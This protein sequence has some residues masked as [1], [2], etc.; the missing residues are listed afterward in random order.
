MMWAA[1]FGRLELRGEGGDTRLRGRFP[2]GAA[3]VLSAGPPERRERFAPRAFAARI[4]AGDDIRLLVG[5]DFGKPLASR[6]AGSLTL[7]DD[8]EALTFEAV[9]P[10]ALRAAPY[11]ADVLAAHAAGLI[12]GLS[13]GFRVPPG[14]DAVQRDGDGL[15]R[16]VRM[17]DLIELS[18]VSAPAYPTA[19]VEAR[20]W[21]PPQAPDAGLQRALARWRA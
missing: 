4:A 3:T 11:V 13:P 9:L 7:Q 17:A 10:Q 19:Q 12:T 20:N 6:A 16:T 21:T 5:H 15:T 14:G 8:D 2:Y 18:V 1:P